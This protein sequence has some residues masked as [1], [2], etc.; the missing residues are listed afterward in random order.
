MIEAYRQAEITVLSAKSYTIKGR[1]LT[2]ENLAEIRN[3]RK[4]WENRLAAVNSG[5]GSMRVSRITPL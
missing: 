4:E 3:G 5:R 2:R 1:V